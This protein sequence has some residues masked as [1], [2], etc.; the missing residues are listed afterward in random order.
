LCIPCICSGSIRYAHVKCLKVTTF[1]EFF[2]IEFKAWIKEKKSVECE[3]C[4]RPYRNKW[5]VWAYEN[6]V[7]K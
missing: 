2:S 4:H 5:K 6:N 7:I 3:I 1:F